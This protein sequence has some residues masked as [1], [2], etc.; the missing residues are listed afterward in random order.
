[1]RLINYFFPI[2]FEWKCHHHVRS[3]MSK[4]S[5][6][7][8]I[9]YIW[10]ISTLM[11]W[12]GLD[13]TD[14]AVSCK[15]DRYSMV[16]KTITELI[17]PLS[18]IVVSLFL[19]LSFLFVSFFV[20]FLVG[21]TQ[22]FECQTHDWKVASSNPCRSSRRI[23]FSRVD[24]LCWLLFWYPVHPRVTAVARKRSRS[25]CQK[26]M[27]QVTAN[28]AFTLHMWLCMKWHGAWLYD[29]QRTCAQMAA[30]SCSTSHGGYSKNIL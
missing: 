5:V 25:F 15:H 16:Q 21:I 7:W 9:F 11:K 22:W 30:V 10:F 28:H 12:R 26:C 29:V 19:S 6:M 18:I 24:F 27:W 3:K 13:I 1:M 20:P 14:T 2:D 17:H 4:Q 23:F 8:Y